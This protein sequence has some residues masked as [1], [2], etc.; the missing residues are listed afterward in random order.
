MVEDG[1]TRSWYIFRESYTRSRPTP[2]LGRRWSN[3]CI[4][5]QELRR[6]R[7]PSLDERFLGCHRVWL[8]EERAFEDNRPG[9]K[10]F[11]SGRSK[12]TRSK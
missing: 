12:S 9:F 7:N 8:G 2:A 11:R 3:G 5:R 10:S 4:G 6:G 1:F